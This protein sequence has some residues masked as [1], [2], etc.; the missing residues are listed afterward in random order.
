V[1]HNGGVE[2][3]AISEE[4]A[5]LESEIAGLRARFDED[6]SSF[7]SL[8]E[9]IEM[10]KERLS[11]AHD[12]VRGTE[13]QLAEK[14]AELAEAQRLER[15]ASYHADLAQYREARARV[16]T[17]VD[18]FLAELEAYDGE[19]V[20]LRKLRDE[21]QEAF[22]SD[23]SVAEVDAALGEEADELM[24]AW[25]AVVGAAEWRIRDTAKAE[26][27][28]NGTRDA[29]E[30]PPADENRAARILEYFSKS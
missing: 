15:L 28:P 16:G 18:T 4:I 2:S 17:A 12:A 29:A 5:R 19:A 27:A 10:L 1:D 14:R 21:L 25:K 20:R 30:T 24:S 9:Q 8:D 11:Q 3:A 22:G 23:E 26:E 6:N 7:S 13:A